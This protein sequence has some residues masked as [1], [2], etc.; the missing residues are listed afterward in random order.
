MALSAADLLPRS[1]CL[2]PARAAE[3]GGRSP[4]AV[5][6]P[7]RADFLPEKQCLSLQKHHRKQK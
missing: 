7:T 3:G 6:D 1:D 2:A 5:Q 4:G